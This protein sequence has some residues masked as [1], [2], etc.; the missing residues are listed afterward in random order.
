MDP[1]GK[2]NA[3]Y[4]GGCYVGLHDEQVCFLSHK[5]FHTFLL[6]AKQPMVIPCQNTAPADVATAP[7]TAV[8]TCGHT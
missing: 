2:W 7:G 4:T 1:Q 5:S 8:E 3:P 6:S